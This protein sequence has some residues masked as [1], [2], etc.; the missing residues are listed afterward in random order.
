MRAEGHRGETS[1]FCASVSTHLVAFF[2]FQIEIL[3]EIVDEICIS[4]YSLLDLWFF[5]SVGKYVADNVFE[6]LPLVSSGIG[7]NLNLDFHI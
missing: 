7:S 1:V 2:S 6:F 4:S 5:T 3:I